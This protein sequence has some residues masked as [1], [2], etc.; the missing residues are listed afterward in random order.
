MKISFACKGNADVF[1]FPFHLYRSSLYSNLYI[2]MLVPFCY[3]VFEPVADAIVVLA[4]WEDVEMKFTSSEC[5]SGS[6]GI[7]SNRYDTGDAT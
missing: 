7:I 5:C 1:F 6:G 4:P 3:N 2:T